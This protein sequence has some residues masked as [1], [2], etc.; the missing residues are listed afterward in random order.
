MR[1][2]SM[3][4]AVL[5]LGLSLSGSALMAQQAGVAPDASAQGS[6]AQAARPSLSDQQRQ[7]MRELRAS[8]RDQ[9]AIIRHDQS[10]NAAQKQEKL[11]ALR[12]STREQMKS[13]LT[14]EQQQA[15]AARRAQAKSNFAAKLNLTDDQQAKLKALRT[16]NRQQRQS[17]LTNPALSNEQKQAQL[18]QLRQNSKAQLATILTPDQLSELQQMRHGRRH[19][20]L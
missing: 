9:A 8:E 18:A 10:L 15:F 7:Q 14:P 1:S 11:K 16:S 13:V 17:V 4:T 12:A 20:Q 3:K 19:K 5:L 2:I 6:A